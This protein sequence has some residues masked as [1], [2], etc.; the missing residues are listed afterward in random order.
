[1]NI[2]Q[3]VF[4]ITGANRGLGLAFARTA[5][6]RGAMKVYAAARDRGT[7]TLPG[8]VPV[9]ID[10]TR[11]ETIAEAA[12]TLGDVTVLVNNAGISRGGGVTGENALER[13][14]EEMETNYF[15]P[16]A[17]SHAF[18]PIL[19]E[20]G[21]GAILNVLSALSWITF[22]RT[23][24]YSASK[25]A[26]WALTN[27]LR[28]ELSGQKT[29]VVALHV[30]YIDT[31]MARHIQIAKVSPD[32][33]AKAGLDALADGRDE[34]LVDEVSRRVHG[35]LSNSVYLQAPAVA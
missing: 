35:A 18:A 11:P 6:E 28:L 17:L 10:V 24:T 7:V 13:A 31:D 2:A 20:N 34:V 29:R 12:K 15:G 3:Q 26:T 19:Q 14:R 32:V 30:G 1:M 21:G 23:T 33:V 4:L 22:P 8:V 25:A 5:L 9:R 16:L 27:G